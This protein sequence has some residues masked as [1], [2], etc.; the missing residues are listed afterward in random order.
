MRKQSAWDEGTKRRLIEAAGEVF[1]KK[2]Y[3]A[4]TVRAI[5]Q[6]AGASVSA[7]N[8]HFKDKEALY[9]AVFEYAHRRAMEK[10]PPDLGLKPGATSEDRL[11]A[12]IRSALLS[13]L[14]SGFPAWHERLISHEMS[15]PTGMLDTVKQKYIQPLNAAM[16]GIAR[17]IMHKASPNHEPDGELVQLGAMNILGACIFQHHARQTMRTVQSANPEPEE[18]EAIAEHIYRFSLAGLR[19]LATDKD[20]KPR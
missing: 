15:N 12:F 11:W 17:E 20:G 3:H 4:A 19:A 16:E 1:A 9:A 7:I 2:G 5:C 13:H 18:I 6:Q 14:D 8:Y 10:Y